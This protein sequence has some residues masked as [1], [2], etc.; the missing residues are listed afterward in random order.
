MTGL[1][2]VASAQAIRACV[3][4]ADN[5]HALAGSENLILN[6]VTCVQRLVLLRRKSIA[7]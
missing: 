6:F 3:A 2:P 7:K 5:H 1:L 4:A